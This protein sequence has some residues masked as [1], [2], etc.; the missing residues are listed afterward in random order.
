MEMSDQVAR[1]QW[2][3]IFHSRHGTQAHGSKAELTPRCG[4]TYA[5]HRWQV[6]FDLPGAIF[7]LR[8]GVCR[9]CANVSRICYRQ[10][11][12]IGLPKK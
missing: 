11:L 6:T 2:V 12:K 1:N 8:A 4:G 10:L 9:S 7:P 3:C 5:Q